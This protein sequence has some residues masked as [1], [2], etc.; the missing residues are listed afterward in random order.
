MNKNFFWQKVKFHLEWSGSC[1]LLQEINIYIIHWDRRKSV[2]LTVY[3]HWCSGIDPDCY[4]ISLEGV[5]ELRQ[6][7]QFPPLAQK[8]IYIK[9]P[10]II[11]TLLCIPSISIYVICCT[12][13]NTLKWSKW[14]TT[15]PQNSIQ[16]LMGP[17]YLYQHKCTTTS[18]HPLR[19]RI[20]RC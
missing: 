10:A 16:K 15:K 2:S 12:R 6:C 11:E 17:S 5:W 14:R 9:F 19:N 7:Y 4:S 18:K 13:A 1:S 8:R 20:Q 3:P